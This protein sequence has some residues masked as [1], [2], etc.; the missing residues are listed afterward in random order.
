MTADNVDIVRRGF[1]A[2]QS[3]DMDGFTAAWD[4]DV[5]WDLRGYR[6]WPGSKTE[7][8]G[9]AE[10]LAEFANYLGS[11]RSLEVRGLEVERLDET[12]VL[13]LHTERR[14]EGDKPPVDLEIGAVYELTTGRVTRVEVYTGHDEARRAAG[15]A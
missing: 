5:V 10:I 1:R 3:L 13:G 11:A 9:T 7:Y 4:P 2:F 12:R 8:R 15:I 14:T 6:G